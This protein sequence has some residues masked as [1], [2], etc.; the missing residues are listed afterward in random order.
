VPLCYGAHRHGAARCRVVIGRF[1]WFASHEAQR[2]NAQKGFSVRERA[3][4]GHQSI[5]QTVSYARRSNTP[6]AQTVRRDT[7]ARLPLE[8]RQ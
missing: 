5:E 8:M 1:H 6:T 4:G 3:G 7:W 2:D